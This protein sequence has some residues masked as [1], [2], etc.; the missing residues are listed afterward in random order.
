MRPYWTATRAFCPHSEDSRAWTSQRRCNKWS[1]WIQ[2]NWR[3]PLMWQGGFRMWTHTGIHPLTGNS[4][5]LVLPDGT[6]TPSGWAVHKIFAT[7]NSGKIRFYPHDQLSLL[8]P[9]RCQSIQRLSRLCLSIHIK[10]PQE[11]SFARLVGPMDDKWLM[12]RKDAFKYFAK[13]FSASR[14]TQPPQQW[15]WRY[16]NPSHITDVFLPVRAL[17]LWLEPSRVAE[18]H[19]LY[20]IRVFS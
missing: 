15:Y 13:D 4:I 6:S 20:R 17:L 14:R 16:P 2:G 1:G 3:I 9:R 7:T 10:G 8:S 12:A 11:W 5:A 18:L 19:R